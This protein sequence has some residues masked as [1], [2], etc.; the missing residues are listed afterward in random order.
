MSIPLF[1]SAPGLA[2][3][4]VP[5]HA[6]L[7]EHA[8]GRFNAIA[9][10]AL[11]LVTEPDSKP[12]VLLLQRA[13]GDSNP[14]KWEPP[15]GACD[16]E[17]P[18]IL[19][20]VAREL[21]EE[22]GLEADHMSRTVGDPHYFSARNGREICR[23]NFLVRVKSELVNDKAATAKLDPVEHQNSVWATEDEVRAGKSGNVVLEFTREEVKQT[24]LQA[25]RSFKA[26]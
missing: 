22:T 20:A 9:T 16:D 18:S 14:N 23:L 15:G 26:T 1:T 11:V 21:R 6:Y 5:K 25:F 19:F 7:K 17:D 4:T 12:R 8:S 10:G 2:E 24:V 13:A 3:F